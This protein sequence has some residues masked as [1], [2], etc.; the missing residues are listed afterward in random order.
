MEDIPLRWLGL[1]LI[2]SFVSLL[3]SP[4]FAQAPLL[5]NTEVLIIYQNNTLKAFTMPT[6]PLKFLIYGVLIDNL[7]IDTI[8]LLDEI[9]KRESGGNPMVC[10]AQFGCS[11]GQG[12]TQLIPS[13]VKYCEEKLG[14]KIDP[15]DPNENIECAVWLLE[16]EG[17]KHWEPYSGPYETN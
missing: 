1:L 16:N 8:Y 2:V 9:I 5:E 15:F 14:K 3:A 7:N 17:I 12:L 11:S 4:N 6:L 10:N 13:T